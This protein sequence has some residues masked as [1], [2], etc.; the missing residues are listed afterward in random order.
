[1]RLQND[2]VAFNDLIKDNKQLDIFNVK[3]LKF[4]KFK[5]SFSR[6]QAIQLN[7]MFVILL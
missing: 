3:Y 4:V 1:M 7:F 5:K 6:P 2:E